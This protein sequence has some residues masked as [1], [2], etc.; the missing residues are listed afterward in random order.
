[1]KKTGDYF[2][3]EIGT[4][5][6]VILL[7][8]NS[9]I[10]AYHNVC[11]HRGSKICLEQSGNKRVLVCPYH[12]WSFNHDGE[13][14]NSRQMG[15]DFD[16]SEFSLRKVHVEVLESLIFI[17]LA[18][19]PP[20]F[21]CMY[22]DV[23]PQLKPVGMNKAKIAFSRTYDVMANW[24]LIVENF[25]EC[26]HCHIGHPEYIRAVEGI[27]KNDPEHVQACLSRWQVLGYD[28]DPVQFLSETWHHCQRYPFHNGF[29]TES[30]D[31]KPVAPLMGDYTEPDMGTFC[32]VA[33]PNFWFES[34]SDHAIT[35]QH[36]PVSP[37]H[38]KL[39]ISW[40]V[41]EDAVEGKDY[42]VDKLIAFW[43][44]T[45]EQDWTLCSNNQAGVNSMAYKPGPYGEAEVEIRK[46]QD[47][48]L[49]KIENA[50]AETVI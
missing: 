23:L 20:S 31:G 28:T 16:K 18:E 4:E 11:T 48:Y 15:D 5:S 8:K 49:N 32:I 10:Q 36:T 35:M 1:M 33:Y 47:W 46:F 39:C 2:T 50:I 26:Y 24:K 41:A 27:H 25:R 45:G 37:T 29:V 40:F 19:T 6:I 12:Q 34:S 22:R 44:I 38:T 3:Y 42:D 9:R 43:K 21:D 30:L 13:L 14:M 7:D 17:S